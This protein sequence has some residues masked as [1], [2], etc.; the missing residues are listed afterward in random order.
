MKYE[1]RANSREGKDLF[2]AFGACGGLSIIIIV[3]SLF[4]ESQERS[5]E[6]IMVGTH[7]VFPRAYLVIQCS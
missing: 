7:V 1:Q 4:N 3:A 6:K 2:C 5:N